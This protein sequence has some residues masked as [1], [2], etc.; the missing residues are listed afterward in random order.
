[1]QGRGSNPGHHK[2][3]NKSY[4]LYCFYEFILHSIYYLLIGCKKCKLIRGILIEKMINP[5]EIWK[6]A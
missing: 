5:I 6:M 2:N 4:H 3:K 1:M